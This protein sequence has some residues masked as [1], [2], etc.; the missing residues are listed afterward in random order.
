MHGFFEQTC[1]CGAGMTCTSF[2]FSLTG[3]P[4]KASREPLPPP[5]DPES[6]N[7]WALSQ[8]REHFFYSRYKDE[9]G[10]FYKEWRRGYCKSV[11]CAL[12]CDS[13]QLPAGWN[14][15]GSLGGKQGSREESRDL[16]PWVWRSPHKEGQTLK[17]NLWGVCLLFWSPATFKPP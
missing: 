17:D 7:P 11:P 4:E 5:P 1:L 13:G 12:S 16:A 10:C 3:S 2:S 15:R 8:T 9:P 6:R 14:T